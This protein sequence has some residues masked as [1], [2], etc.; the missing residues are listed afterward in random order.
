MRNFNA[1]KRMA[2]LQQTPRASAVPSPGTDGLPLLEPTEVIARLV[3][4]SRGEAPNLKPTGFKSKHSCIGK[5]YS[6][7]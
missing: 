7:Y 4:Y 2:L 5:L 1:L 3:G 6:D